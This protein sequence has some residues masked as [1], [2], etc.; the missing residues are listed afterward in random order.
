MAPVEQFPADFLLSLI[1][2]LV[3]L[4]YGIYRWRLVRS[5]HGEYM[6]ER[7]PFKN[8]GIGYGRNLF[9][10]LFLLFAG[11]GALLAAVASLL[12]ALT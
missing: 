5:T 10:A 11:T 2:A 1:I 8:E 12:Q 6:G 9:G 4:P 7:D 3:A